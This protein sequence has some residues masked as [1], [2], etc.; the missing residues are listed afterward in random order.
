MRFW[1]VLASRQTSRRLRSG[2]WKCAT[3]AFM[4]KHGW[5][6][7]FPC[8]V[9]PASP[10]YMPRV[11]QPTCEPSSLPLTPHL[12]CL[13]L[14]PPFTSCIPTKSFAHSI[15]LRKHLKNSNGKNPAILKTVSLR[16]ICTPKS[17]HETCPLFTFGNTM[18]ALTTQTYEQTNIYHRTDQRIA[19]EFCYRTGQ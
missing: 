2:D 4:W 9:I 17:G 18:Q 10:A 6:I 15:L 12:P 13:P 8:P 5:L 3:I 19:G 14:L 7:T 11:K 16:V 1:H